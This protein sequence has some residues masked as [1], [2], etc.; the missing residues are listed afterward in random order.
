MQRSWKLLVSELE[1]EADPW[2]AMGVIPASSAARLLS[3]SLQDGTML[4]QIVPA[5]LESPLL[6]THIPG[7]YTRLAM[8]EPH[9]PGIVNILDPHLP[10]IEPH[11][12]LILE[13]LP[14]IEPHLPFVLRCARALE[15]LEGE[16]VCGR[17]TMRSGFPA[18]RCSVKGRG[19]SLQK[20]ACCSCPDELLQRCYLLG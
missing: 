9:M 2:Y 3:Q 14:D 8:L 19:Q 5:A 17:W 10:S 15:G 20:V 4:G 12:D 13:R 1:E 7:V 6:F 11:L 18:A 16:R